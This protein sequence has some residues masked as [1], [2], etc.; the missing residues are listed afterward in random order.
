MSTEQKPEQKSNLVK[1]KREFGL[2]NSPDAYIISV[3]VQN[4]MATFGEEYVR[5]ILKELFLTPAAKPRKSKK[6]GNE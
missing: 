5:S 6:V 2:E 1:P 3:H 4:M